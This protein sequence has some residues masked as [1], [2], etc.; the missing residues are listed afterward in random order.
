VTSNRIFVDYARF[1]ATNN[2]DRPENNVT[3]TFYN[4]NALSLSDRTPYQDGVKMTSGFTE[5]QDA[6]TYIFDINLP[7]GGTNFNFSVGEGA[8]SNPS[9]STVS[10]GGSSSS[11][12]THDNLNVVFTGTATDPDADQYKILVCLTGAQTNGACDATTYCESNPLVNSGSQASCTKSGSGLGGSYVWY[13]FACDTANACSGPNQGSGNT[14]NPFEINRRPSCAAPSVTPVSPLLYTDSTATCD[15]TSD[16]SDPDSDAENT[17]NR[18][19]KWF[20]NGAEIN[21]Q[22][23]ST[24]AL[25]TSTHGDKGDVITCTWKTSDHHG[26]YA[27]AYSSA[28]AGNTISNSKPTTPSGSTFD[29]NPIFV[30]QSLTMTGEG[31]TD[32]DG[33]GFTYHFEFYENST[34]GTLLQ[35]KSTTAALSPAISQAQSTSTIIIKVWAHDGT[36]FSAGY[37]TVTVPISRSI[38]LSLSSDLE[39]GINFTTID[40][41]DGTEFAADDNGVGSPTTYSITL[42]GNGTAPTLFTYAGGN[43]ISGGDSILITN[44]KFQ[45]TTSNQPSGTKTPY[46]TTSPG[47]N[48]TFQNP[49]TPLTLYFRYFLTVPGGTKS[50]NYGTTIY[51]NASGT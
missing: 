3:L 15:V 42:E 26:H 48:I 30:G 11:T 39:D 41:T 37:E 43:W 47:T 13:M 14:G 19:F 46:V 28:S 27:A 25:G 7:I 50:G 4:T 33:D 22:I 32:A 35:A 29:P 40:S 5:L 6:D 34:G 23:S 21:N 10:D 12:P 16:Y 18:A 44:F 36:D 1:H 31:S 9:L 2:P 24:I 51:F 45:N 8:N 38:A 20:K 17:G 49:S